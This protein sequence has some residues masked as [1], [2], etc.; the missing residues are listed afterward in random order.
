MAKDKIT[1]SAQGYEDFMNHY[2]VDNLKT[3]NSDGVEVPISEL[4]KN[5]L[6]C[7]VRAGMFVPNKDQYIVNEKMH[8]MYFAIHHFME[9]GNHLD[10]FDL[11]CVYSGSFLNDKGDQL[12]SMMNFVASY[13][14]GAARLV[15]SHRDHYVH[16]AYV[17]ILGLALFN[18][19]SAF[20]ESFNKTYIANSKK[21][22]ECYS[23][24]VDLWGLTALFHDIGYQYEIPFN[25]IR[26]NNKFDYI[27]ISLKEGD[28]YSKGNP[29]E[30][31]YVYLQYKNM[32]KYTNLTSMFRVYGQTLKNK[33]LYSDEHLDKCAKALVDDTFLPKDIEDVL[34]YH[35]QR[36][37]T[38]RDYLDREKIADKLRQKNTPTEMT[39]NKDKGENTYQVF[40]DHAYYSGIRLFKQMVYIYGLKFCT[41][42]S[43]LTEVMDALTAITMH[44]K[45]FEFELS[46][47]EHMQMEEHPLAYLLILCDELQCWDRTSFGKSSLKQFHA[48]DCEFEF[49]DNVIVANYCFDE[50]N[51]A[52]SFKN[53]KIESV[54]AGPLEKF[55]INN[56][57]KDKNGKKI[58]QYIDTLNP[59]VTKDWDGNDCTTWHVASGD[60]PK[61]DDCKFLLSINDIVDCT[62][63][64]G[65]S[66]GVSVKASFK[67]AS[68]KYCRE[69]LTTI[70][71]EDVYK[72]AE[73]SYEHY[74]KGNKEVSAFKDSSRLIQDKLHDIM[75]IKYVGEM[76]NEVHCF[77]LKEQKA[78]NRILQWDDFTDTEKNQ[79]TDVMVKYQNRFMSENRIVF[80]NYNADNV[81]FFDFAKEHSKEWL[82]NLLKILLKYPGIE[83]YRI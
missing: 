71:M 19:Q 49:G 32:D 26:E 53:G 54:V 59:D 24:F 34:A 12:E 25:Q 45:F 47:R 78:F 10:A 5:A 57:K 13:E 15:Q 73:K 55:L 41:N 66:I 82:E 74:Y 75:M 11:Y 31:R 62:G 81:D 28:F 68:N 30:I 61:G 67:K 83:V 8:A 50:K 63:S 9:T 77:A 21:E 40:M 46:N 1:V 56:G 44:N 64:Q 35:I 48:L 33:M 43:R 23:K 17:F 14:N 36:K 3:L 69:Y 29:A 76:L 51:D 38:S 16:S 58:K 52:I 60:Y 18:T 4:E 7:I 70:S 27:D 20:R 79:M 22:Y 37:F 72:L 39:P 6:E 42:T 2:G 80:E 65:K